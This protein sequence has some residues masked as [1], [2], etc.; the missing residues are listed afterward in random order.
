MLSNSEAEEM[1]FLL[2][3]SQ[4]WDVKDEDLAKLARLQAKA[5]REFI[6]VEKAY[7]IDSTDYLQQTY[8]VVDKD[9]FEFTISK[10]LCDMTV[11]QFEQLTNRQKLI[12]IVCKL[13]S[14]LK[15]NLAKL[16]E[17]VKN[18][19]TMLLDMK[20]KTEKVD[21]L[22]ASLSLKETTDTQTDLSARKKDKTPGQILNSH[23]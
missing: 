6:T 9:V 11:D 3:P 2:N 4:L 17:G 5:C 12:C 19:E 23:F 16:D 20:Q 10:L 21:E 15:H 22:I 13:S 7:N 8:T 14:R 1:V 18:M